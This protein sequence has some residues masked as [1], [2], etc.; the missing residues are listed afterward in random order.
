MGFL[1]K[2]IINHQLVIKIMKITAYLERTKETKEIDIKDFKDIF[3]KLNLNPEAMLVL[4]DNQ[5]ITEKT[6]LKENDKVRIMPVI[7]GG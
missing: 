7:S 1:I 5:L 2:N 6:K 4:R 3:M